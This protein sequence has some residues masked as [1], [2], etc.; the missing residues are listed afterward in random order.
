MRIGVLL[1][2]TAVVAALLLFMAV[3]EMLLL[4]MAAVVIVL[5]FLPLEKVED[6]SIKILDNPAPPANFTD[7]IFYLNHV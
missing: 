2:T 4:S 1:A 3:V 5:S 7:G 6:E